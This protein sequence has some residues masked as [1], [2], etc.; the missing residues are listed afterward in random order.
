LARLRRSLSSLPAQ[1]ANSACSPSAREL[2]RAVKLQEHRQP[3]HH[4]RRPQHPTLSPELGL[5]NSIRCPSPSRR[6]QAPHRSRGHAAHYLPS[7]R[8]PQ[9]L[10]APSLPRELPH[11]VKLQEHRQPAHHLRRPQ[12]PT[13]SPELGLSNSI[14]CPSPS[15]RPQA[16]HRSRGHAAGI[17]V[18]RWRRAASVPV[19]RRA[20][21]ADLPT[22]FVSFR[23]RVSEAGAR[24]LGGGWLA[25]VEASGRP[26]G[27]SWRGCAPA[28]GRSEPER[29]RRPC[30]RRRLDWRREEEYME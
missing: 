6:P 30:P 29:R 28:G 18:A 1:A 23:S 26:A 5:S 25:R 10:H 12:H 21:A 16:P 9:I 22:A 8:R 4:L 3:A 24:R 17:V 19:A 11:V 27:V 15:R 14:R 7:P 2:P 20:R 13:L